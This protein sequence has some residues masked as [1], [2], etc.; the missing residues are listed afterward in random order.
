M[1]SVPED[2]SY[3]AKGGDPAGLSNTAVSMLCIMHTPC[4][5]RHCHGTPMKVL[6]AHFV[7]LAAAKDE[8]IWRLISGRAPDWKQ[9]P[10]E[11]SLKHPC[12]LVDGR[13]RQTVC[14]VTSFFACRAHVRLIC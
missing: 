7:H 1:D 12:R 4:Q 6:A 11:G 5:Y 9:M 3:M 8:C 14:Q 2:T 13:D 10:F